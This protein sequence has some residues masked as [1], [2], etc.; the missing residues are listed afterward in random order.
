MAGQPVWDA[1]VAETEKKGLP[2]K[3]ALAKVMEFAKQAASKS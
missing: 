1:W 3:E 2:G